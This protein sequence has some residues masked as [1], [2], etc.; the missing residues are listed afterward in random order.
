I[1][2]ETGSLAFG[3][4]PVQGRVS[5]GDDFAR[6]EAAG[7]HPHGLA[8]D[9]R[10]GAPAVA[11]QD[12]TVEWVLLPARLARAFAQP[13]APAA[14]APAPVAVADPQ[15]AAVADPPS[16]LSPPSPLPVVQLG[17]ALQ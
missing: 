17:I 12:L 3:R 9:A 6:A 11:T 5:Y 15:P 14:P 1:L 13:E 7:L 10:P 2:A 16:V 8:I 4:F